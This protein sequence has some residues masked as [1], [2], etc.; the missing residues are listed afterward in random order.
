MYCAVYLS[1]ILCLRDTC[2]WFLYNNPVLTTN[3]NQPMSYQKHIR[4]EESVRFM[5]YV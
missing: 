4:T 1:L 3:N 5:L 2:I